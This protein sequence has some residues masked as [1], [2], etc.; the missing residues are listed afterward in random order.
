MMKESFDSVKNYWMKEVKNN[1]GGDE[2]LVLLINKSD[3]SERDF[4]YEEA[5]K[6]AEKE[7]MIVYETSAKT[8]K[9]V[10]GAFLEIC[11]LLMAKR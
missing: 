8:G 7:N 11:R 2:Q 1:S 5:R 9:N 6:Y 10:T 3:L 4:E